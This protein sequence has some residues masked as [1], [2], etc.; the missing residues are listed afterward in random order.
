MSLAL[1][2]LIFF[3]MEQYIYLY[4][5]RFNLQTDDTLTVQNK[6]KYKK[7]ITFIF[8]S[9]RNLHVLNF[10]V[11]F[12]ILTVI[13]CFS[14]VARI[15]ALST[16]SIELRTGIFLSSTVNTAVFITVFAVLS[17][18]TFCWAFKIHKNWHYFT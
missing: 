5:T 12:W 8:Q 11:S 6:K 3:L 9:H 4:C 2:I 16:G 18:G 10:T 17:R 1:F 14:Y 15:T 13:T 7:K